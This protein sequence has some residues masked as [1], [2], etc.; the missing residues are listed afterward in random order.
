LFSFEYCTIQ[1]K[2]ILS[3]DPSGRVFYIEGVITQMWKESE[4]NETLARMIET[5]VKMIDGTSCNAGMNGDQTW[6]VDIHWKEQGLYGQTNERQVRVQ[7]VDHFN[8]VLQC[9]NNRQRG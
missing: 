2:V 1:K 3:G 9:L 4:M 5:E 7:N 6:W 8:Q